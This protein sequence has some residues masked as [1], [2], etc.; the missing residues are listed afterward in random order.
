MYYIMNYEGYEG[1]VVYTG[2]DVPLFTGY[3]KDAPGCPSFHGF[4]IQE[5]TQ[6]FYAS[7]DWY[8]AHPEAANDVEHPYKSRERKHTVSERR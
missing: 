3:V 6:N 7:V 5:A 1:I 2:L 4:T 8:L